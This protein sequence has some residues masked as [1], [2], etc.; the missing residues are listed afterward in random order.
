VSAEEKPGSVLPLLLPAICVALGP[1][2]DRLLRH[3]GL[4]VLPRA[5]TVGVL[6]GV[7]SLIAYLTLGRRG[8]GEVPREPRRPLV[9]S[10]WASLVVALVVVVLEAVGY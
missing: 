4:S 8:R 7:L 10:L 3:Q 5:V 9:A 2:L 1:I 6:V